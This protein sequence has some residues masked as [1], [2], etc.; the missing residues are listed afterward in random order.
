M[1]GTDRHRCFWHQSGHEAIVKQLLKTGKFDVDLRDCIGETPLLRAAEH[2]HKAVVKLLL[3]TG[4]VEIDRRNKYGETP[5]LRAAKNGHIAVVNLLL[6]TGKVEINSKDTNC[7]RTPLYWAL[8][9]EHISCFL[10][11]RQLY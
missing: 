1:H 8:L 3:E 11:A 9:G 4:K 10:S 5:L 6:E 7:R 2:G